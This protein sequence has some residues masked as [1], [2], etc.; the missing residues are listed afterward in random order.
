MAG[1]WK[2][3]AK[4]K[5]VNELSGKRMKNTKQGVI[6]MILGSKTVIRPVELGDEEFLYKWWND[7]KL[8]EHAGFPSGLLESKEKIKSDIQNE[9]NSG[10]Y[11]ERRR[12]IICLKEDLIPIGEINY[13]D[14]D[15][16]NQKC[17]IGIKI[18]EQ[19]EQGKGY[20]YDALI[21]FIDYVFN[22]LN[23]N[24]IELTTMSDNVRAQNLYKKL[25]FR[26]F[27][28]STDGYFNAAKGSFNDVVYME[29][30]KWRWREISKE[31]S[32]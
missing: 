9:Q 4:I 10:I 24:K 2:F 13:H 31:V 32:F 25:G 12:F 15:A 29:L 17:K 3:Y 26:K 14:W 18:C 21:S 27:G 1:V 22:H 7:G 11:S 16:R 20:G 6:E 19:V 28:I 23:L 30:L 5:V 8:M